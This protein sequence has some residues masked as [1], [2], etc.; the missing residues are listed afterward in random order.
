MLDKVLIGREIRSDVIGRQLP[1]GN[2]KRQEPLCVAKQS[3]AC[4]ILYNGLWQCAVVAADNLDGIK[5]PFAT[6]RYWPTNDNLLSYLPMSLV[7]YP[8]SPTACGI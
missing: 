3:L 1:V 7:L 5:L 4:P 6:G 2:R 8:V